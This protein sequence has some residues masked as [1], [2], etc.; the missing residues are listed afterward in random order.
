MR[1]SDFKT[2]TIFKQRQNIGNDKYWGIALD[3]GYSAVKGFSPNS[4]FSFPSYAE[5]NDLDSFISNDLDPASIQYKDLE[6]GETWIVGE[7]AQDSVSIENPKESLNSLYGRNRYFSPMFK[8]IA[9]VGLAFG[10]VINQFDSPNGRPIVLQ[11]GLPPEYAKSDTP[12]IVEA[13]TGVHKFAVKIGNNPWVKYDFVIPQNNIYVM[14]QPMGTLF[15]I[16]TANDGRAIPEAAKYFK[17][18]MLI[19]DPGFGTFDVFAMKNKMIDSF[20]TFDNLGM[21]R[22]LKETSDDI[23]RQ[24]GTEIPVSA[25]QKFLKEGTFPYVNKRQ[26]KS[27]IINFTPILEKNNKKICLEAIEKVRDIYNFFEEYEYLVITSGTG[28]AW[29]EIIREYLSGMN[30]LKIISGNQNDDLPYILSNVRGYYMYLI[31]T[32]RCL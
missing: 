12:L 22:V 13:L 18:N 32:L 30:T 14:G 8:V 20:E 31:N 27:E 19:L 17:S 25:M 6:T 24:Y 10:Y 9:R 23:Q 11:T 21:K 28:A 4:V 26:M 16:S 3:I 15:S 1:A 29:S 5:R 2:R 7:V